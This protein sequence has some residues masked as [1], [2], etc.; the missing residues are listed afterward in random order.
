MKI[1]LRENEDKVLQLFDP[2]SQKFFKGG[3]VRNEEFG[4]NLLEVANSVVRRSFKSIMEL[5]QNNVYSD[6]GYLPSM[7][8][9]KYIWM[10]PDIR[11]K[12]LEK[13]DVK[14]DRKTQR[15]S[16]GE[17]RGRKPK[18]DFSLNEEFEAEIREPKKRGRPRKVG[19]EGQITEKKIPGKR[20][21][22]RK[23][24]ELIEVK[25]VKK[26]KPKPEVDPNAVK[27][28][29]GRPRKV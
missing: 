19:S 29:R 23:N 15:K 22:P 8:A 9:D 7:I 4:K 1:E 25:E 16:K 28:G 3:C 14:V 5:A 10:N 18:P 17:K 13:L 26:R 21:R 6:E 11:D 27:R 24:P 20:G 2:R 12:V